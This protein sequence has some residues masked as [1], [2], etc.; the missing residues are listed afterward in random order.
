MEA[1]I[2][3]TVRCAL[4]IPCRSNVRADSAASMIASAANGAGTNTIAV[5]VTRETDPETGEQVLA[6]VARRTYPSM[7]TEAAFS[8]VTL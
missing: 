5:G 4:E 8:P 6:R 1:S 3:G 2:V 7:V